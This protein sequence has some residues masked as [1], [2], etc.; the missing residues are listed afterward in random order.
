LIRKEGAHM[1]TT[2]TSIA[3]SLALAAPVLLL[4][5]RSKPVE[6]A[7]APAPVSRNFTGL[8]EGVDKKGT[9]YTVRFAGAEWE[10]HIEKDG[11][12]LPYYRGTYTFSGSSLDLRV[13]Q[14]ADPVTFEWVPERGNFPRNVSGRLTGGRLKV[15]ALTEIELAKRH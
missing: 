8:W 4:G 10:C 7:P 9:I 15:P 3:I 2:A 11:A 1:K 6:V 14:E 13:L 5:C 12:R